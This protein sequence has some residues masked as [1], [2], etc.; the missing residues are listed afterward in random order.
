MK[1]RHYGWVVSAPFFAVHVAAIAGVAV[2]GWSWKGFALA[3]ALYFI[4]MFGVTGAYHRY[5]SHR[6]YRTSRWFQFVLAWLAQTSFQKGALWWAAH[7]RDHHKYSD[8]KLDPHSWRE[9]GFWWSH[10]GWILSRNTE[11]TDFKKIGD[12]ARYPELRWLNTYHLV[13]GVLLGVGLWLAGGWH[14][15][16]WGLFVS[17][18]LLWHGTFAINSL[19]HW[20]GRRRYP[21]TD[22]SKNSLALALVTMGEGWHNNHHYYPRSVRQGFFWW[23]IDCTYYI[24]RA[25]SVVG[26]VWDL[27]VPPKAVLEGN[28][29]AGRPRAVRAPIGAALPALNALPEPER[30]AEAAAE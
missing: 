16:V 24:L 5:F 18:S 30:T 8:T 7:H 28:I 23:E 3:M 2:L 17:T 13:P 9:E 1:K 26:L 15:L 27:H 22:D 6:T 10:V 19:A 21:T 25:L 4:R 29:D 20:W 11:E 12:L 14:A